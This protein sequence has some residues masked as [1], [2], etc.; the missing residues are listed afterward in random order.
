MNKLVRKGAEKFLLHPA[1]GDIDKDEG[2]TLDEHA[3][4]L[5]WHWAPHW[6]RWLAC[7][8]NG[9]WCWFELEPSPDRTGW[10]RGG[11]YE[12]VSGDCVPRLSKTNWKKSLEPRQH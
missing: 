7:D 2:M 11:N 9:D 1:A 3:W 4:Q 10:V 6:A 5:R 12:D 8:G